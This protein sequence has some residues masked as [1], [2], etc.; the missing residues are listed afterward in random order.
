ME[1]S[2]DYKRIVEMNVKIFKAW[3]NSWL[4]SYI[5]TLIERPKWFQDEKGVSVGDVVLILKSEFDLTYQYGIVYKGRDDRIRTIEV[6]YQ[7]HNE[8]IKRKTVRGVRE[9]VVIHRVDELPSC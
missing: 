1:I 3:F 8:N 5:Q 7:N 6:E 4:I 9:V 2:H